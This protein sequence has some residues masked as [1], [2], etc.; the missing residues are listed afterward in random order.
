MIYMR[1]VNKNAQEQT[2]P[3]CHTKLMVHWWPPWPIILSTASSTVA[4]AALL[5][6]VDDNATSVIVDAKI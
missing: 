1:Q 4:A 3:I 6:T 2:S 5:S